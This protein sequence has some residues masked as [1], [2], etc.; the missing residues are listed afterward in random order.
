[1]TLLFAQMDFSKENEYIFIGDNCVEI[2]FLSV[3]KGSALKAQNLLPW[4]K[5]LSFKG[6]LH[7]LFFTLPE[8]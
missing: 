2:V 7:N 1:M 8:L 6:R 4:E 5:I 3:E